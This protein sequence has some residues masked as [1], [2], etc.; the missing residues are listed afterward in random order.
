MVE[1]TNINGHP[2]YEDFGT[3]Q[4]EAVEDFLKERD[5]FAVDSARERLLLTFNPG[6]WLRK[7][8]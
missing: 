5:G 3:S 4:M 7:L 1:D 2:V 8:R 6:G